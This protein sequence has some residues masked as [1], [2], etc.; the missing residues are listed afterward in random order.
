M[1]TPTSVI[2]AS[3]TYTVN[4]GAAYGD[5]LTNS[6]Y[7]PRRKR[8]TLPLA[9]PRQINLVGTNSVY[10]PRRKRPTLP[11]AHPR[12]INLVG[13]KRLDGGTLWGL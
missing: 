8:P 13:L 10:L 2:T 5:G 3:N 7:L 9:H 12:Q 4:A 1:Y 6:V 11:L